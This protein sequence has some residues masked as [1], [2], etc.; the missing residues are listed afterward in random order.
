MAI[1]DLFLR[2]ADTLD[3]AA[4]AAIETCVAVA[5]D[6]VGRVIAM[7]V[8]EVVPVRPMALIPNDLGS[9]VVVSA[10]SCAGLRQSDD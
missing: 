3:A 5:G 2:W 8:D 1:K 4:S 7:A 10:A 6:L 9:M